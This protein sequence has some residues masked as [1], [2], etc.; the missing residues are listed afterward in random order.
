[1]INLVSLKLLVIPRKV[2]S[3]GRLGEEFSLEL[4][5]AL[6]KELL[7]GKEAIVYLAFGERIC[8]EYITLEV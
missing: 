2:R 8:K 3:S 4:V 6:Q 7:L 1:M 5:N